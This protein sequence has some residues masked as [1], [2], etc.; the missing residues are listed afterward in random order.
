M[1]EHKNTV[2][3]E[4]VINKDRVIRPD[5]KKNKTDELMVPKEPKYKI[6][7]IVD[8]SN[9][10][11]GTVFKE[12]ENTFIAYV[13]EEGNY[14]ALITKR[15]HN[16]VSVLPSQELTTFEE[17][18][19][20]RSVKRDKDLSFSE[21]KKDS[22]IK[23]QQLKR[24]KIKADAEV[25]A[26]KAKII[27]ADEAATSK[28]DTQSQK[29]LQDSEVSEYS[30]TSK[31]KR[32]PQVN[33]TE[34]LVKTE[35]VNNYFKKLTLL[36]VPKVQVHQKNNL[37]RRVEYTPNVER[38]FAAPTPRALNIL[39]Q[40]G[41]IDAD[42]DSIATGV[43]KEDFKRYYSMFI[44]QGNKLSYLSKV[45]VSSF[46][47]VLLDWYNKDL[48][49][50]IIRD[51]FNYKSVAELY[52]DL[53]AIG[54]KADE[55]LIEPNQ[56]PDEITD[57]FISNLKAQDLSDVSVS[58]IKNKQTF[59]QAIRGTELN[60]LRLSYEYK[61]VQKQVIK[62]ALEERSKVLKLGS[63]SAKI[64]T[65]KNLIRTRPFLDLTT[66][67]NKLY[68]SRTELL[69]FIE[70]NNLMEL[71][72]R[73]V[74]DY[75]ITDFEV[76]TFLKQHPNVTITTLSKEFEVVPN[77]IIEVLDRNNLN[78]KTLNITKDTL[79]TYFKNLPLSQLKTTTTTADAATFF[80]ISTRQFIN[81]IDV[82]NIDFNR[83]K[84]DVIE[85]KEA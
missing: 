66:I 47:I 44:K 53:D 63:T 26:K 6:G 17:L 48:T 74:A 14:K 79:I 23:N 51:E 64:K 84:S 46:F 16:I 62:Q 3:L 75:Q 78:K 8:L 33:Q 15:G 34:H 29:G 7:Q 71:T 24:E 19:H 83:L 25:K 39:M 72:E 41:Y 18:Q 13:H 4:T 68:T 40:K 60:K 11:H 20:K 30:D 38:L 65:Y 70:Q 69:N 58:V 37:A 76:I 9:G 32:K 56:E 61:Y 42:V 73:N 21:G 59:L 10:M 57:N 67:A 43:S 82:Y 35:V 45:V 28:S 1:T 12:Y 31:Y 22:Y 77:M 27:K 54:F 2:D 52:S 81:Y 85:Q 49:L 5:N 36:D 80:G 55:W 50:D